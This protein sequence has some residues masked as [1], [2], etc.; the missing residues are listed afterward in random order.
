MKLPIRSVF[1]WSLSIERGLAKIDI[2]QEDQKLLTK[3]LDTTSFLQPFKISV[4]RAQY[5]WS[6]GIRILEIFK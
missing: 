6:E 5:H 4:F 2:Y 3:T 1:F